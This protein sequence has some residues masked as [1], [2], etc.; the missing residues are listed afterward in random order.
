[1]NRCLKLSGWG[2]DGGSSTPSLSD[3]GQSLNTLIG[4]TGQPRAGGPGDTE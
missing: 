3:E 1:M 4:Y 2:E